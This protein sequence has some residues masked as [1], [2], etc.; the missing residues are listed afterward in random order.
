MLFV[1]AAL[2]A[3]SSAV[4]PLATARASTLLTAPYSS[5]YTDPQPACTVADVPLSGPPPVGAC[6]FTPNPTASTG[7][8]TASG[9]LQSPEDGTLPWNA[10]LLSETGVVARYHLDSPTAALPITVTIHV[11]S[12]SATVDVPFLPGLVPDT[13]D[14]FAL[15]QTVAVDVSAVAEE[16]QCMPDCVTGGDMSVVGREVS[17]TS[18]VSGQDYVFH[19]TLSNA[20]GD[21]VLPDTSCGDLP[22]GDVLV[23]P[24]VLIFANDELAWGSQYAQVDAVATSVSVG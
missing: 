24:E 13:L 21:S 14:E 6:S 17:G 9:V 5:T 16:T 22:A 11:K 20:C 23:M 15:N 8:I 3:A 10:S 7:E 19:L 2:A 4:L 1:V 18:S 12:A